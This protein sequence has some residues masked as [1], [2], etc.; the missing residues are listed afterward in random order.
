MSG[1][2]VGRRPQND[3]QL[4]RDMDTRI[5]AL[6]QRNSAR[7]GS[8]TIAERDGK[9]LAIRPGQEIHLDGSPIADEFTSTLRSYASNS[10]LSTTDTKVTEII[11]STVNNYL[12]GEGQ[13]FTPQE[14]SIA[15]QTMYLSV[16]STAQTVQDLMAKTTAETHAGVSYRI[17]FSTYPDG[18]L[19][20]DWDLTYSGAG[21][22]YVEI[23]DG[24]AHWHR[25]VD[26]D[27]SLLA[28]YEPPGGGQTVSDYQWLGGTLATAMQRDAQNGV[29]GRCNAAKDTYVFAY[30]T[31]V[32]V[33]SFRAY[34]GCFVSGAP[35]FFASDIEA[36]PNYN[37]YLRLG[38]AEGGSRNFQV[39]S[40]NE[41]II[42][43]TDFTAV[44][45]MGSDYRRWGWT[46]ATANGGNYIPG[47]AV[48]VTCADADPAMAGS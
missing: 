34:L 3:Q 43:Y 22:G 48:L 35:T 31:R 7:F 19:P 44:S 20:D 15:Q 4:I 42:D 25:I 40:G 38:T 5:R 26:G 41:V 1:S 37:L 10:D 29:A 9:L 33:T 47:E 23:V 46:N 16:R 13:G 32:S 45:A 36:N 30:G 6:E 27:R 8:W 12:G 17:D 21:S 14:A 2:N 39:V 11:D 28:I 18:A 24:K